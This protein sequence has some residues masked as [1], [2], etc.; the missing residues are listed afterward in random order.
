MAP[1][2]IQV[3]AELEERAKSKGLVPGT[4]KFKEFVDPRGITPSVVEDIIK[5][6][7]KKPGNKPDSWEYTG[8]DARVITNGKG[9]VVTVVPY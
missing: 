7:T 8:R 5:N 9:D 6:G 3:R 4:Q 1:D 2:T